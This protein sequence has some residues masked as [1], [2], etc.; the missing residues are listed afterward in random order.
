[1]SDHKGIV[2]QLPAKLTVP[3]ATTFGKVNWSRQEWD[4]SLGRIAPLLLRLA[5][6]IA[7]MLDCSALRAPF[8]GGSCSKKYRRAVLDAAAWARN[9][10][11]VVVGHTMGLVHVQVPKRRRVEAKS[12]KVLNPDSYHDFQSFKRVVAE[13]VWRGQR[14]QVD[15]F[16]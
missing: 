15:A 6:S 11:Y 5:T 16:F 8:F 7:V 13:E 4:M 9:V 10:L 1:M 12:A 2:T 14:R 3:L